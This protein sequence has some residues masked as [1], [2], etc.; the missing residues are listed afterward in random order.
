MANTAVNQINIDGVKDPDVNYIHA[1]EN[2]SIAKAKS[3]K[4]IINDQ[5]ALNKKR[6]QAFKDFKKETGHGATM[7]FGE[8]LKIKNLTKLFEGVKFSA[9]ADYKNSIANYKL[10]LIE[11]YED[12]DAIEQTL[13]FANSDGEMEDEVLSVIGDID[14]NYENFSFK[15]FIKKVGNVALAPVKATV[16]VTKYSVKETAKAGKFVGK[17]AEGFVKTDIKNIGK[18]IIQ[19]GNYASK[20]VGQAAKW[21]KNNA[22]E[23]IKSSALQPMRL[24]FESVIRM[25]VFGL[26]SDMQDMKTKDKARYD[27]AR[28]VWRK[29]GG[30]RP[31]FDKMV[32]QGSKVKGPQTKLKWFKVKSADGV[33]DTYYYPTGVEESVAV[34][35]ASTP[36]ITAIIGAMGKKPSGM[37][38]QSANLIKQDAQSGNNAQITQ[39]VDDNAQNIPSDDYEEPDTSSTAIAAAT[40]SKFPTWAYFAIGGG[41]I[42]IGGILYFVFSKK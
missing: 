21:V 22:W 4:K 14:E 15:S 27:N 16:D 12:F 23:L 8:W 10:N 1:S 18:G 36:I 28:N 7:R 33:D 34:V 25:N 24:A 32:T 20:K 19:A 40:K 6:E 38:Q 30:N 11:H 5:I 13:Q 31:A 37:D 42:V 3:I 35:A 39:T 2:A 26:A 41:V 9:D 29:W 17:K